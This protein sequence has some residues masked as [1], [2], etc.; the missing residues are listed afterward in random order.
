MSERNE[1]S[2]GYKKP[3]VYSQFKKGKSGNPSGRPRSKPTVSTML[4]E[5]IHAVV[6]VTENG[7][8][9]KLSKLRLMVKQVLNKAIAGNFQP[10]KYIVGL[11]GTLEGINQTPTKTQDRPL[12]QKE[13]QAMPLQELTDLLLKKIRQPL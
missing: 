12:T 9:I 6:V 13:L 5:E 4:A 7:Q 3:P 10:L 8:R 11:L 2:V 1:P